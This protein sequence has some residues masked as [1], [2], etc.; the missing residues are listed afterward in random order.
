[1]KQMNALAEKL[2]W[3]NALTKNCT[4]TIWHRTKAVGSG[5]ALDWRL[6]AN[7]AYERRT[8]NTGILLDELKR[9]SD[10]T[11]RARSSEAVEDFSKAIREGLPPRPRPGDSADV[12]APGP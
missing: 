5:P 7:L 6:L 11:A 8:V 9:R 3:Y 10:I 1:V 2:R 12:A 4:T